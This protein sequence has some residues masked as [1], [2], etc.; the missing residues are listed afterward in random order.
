MLGSR[1][2]TVAVL[3]TGIARGPEHPLLAG[4]FDAGADDDDEFDHDGDGELDRQA[5]HG[6]FISGIVR[7]FAPAAR[8]FV[9]RVLTSAGDG[10]DFS[11]AAG[12]QQT[13]DRLAGTPLDILNLSLGGH[14]DEDAPPI[15]LGAVLADVQA[16]GTVV[17]AA[18]GNT[19]SCRPFYPA[20]LPGVIGVAALDCN[21]PASFTCSGPWVRA[22]APGVDV[23][24]TF[25]LPPDAPATPLL[26]PDLCTG[27]A[28]WSGTSFAAPK[29]AGA[30]A[31]FMRLYD[32]DAQEAVRRLLDAPGLFRLPD[33]GTV[34]NLA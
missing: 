9:D 29:V 10:D 19:A 26:D 22:C 25:F 23:H 11:V 20:A 18:A 4:F 12:L 32:V 24:S 7:R 34:V 6:T 15:A 2:V 27:W 13:L 14:T 17:V 16:A 33:L 30:L 8:L 21:R 31:A 28:T 3:D 5:G 1:E